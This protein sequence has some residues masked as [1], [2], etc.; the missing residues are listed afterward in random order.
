MYEVKWKDLSPAE[1]TFEPI[2]RHKRFR[3][4][5]IGCVVLCAK[6]EGGGLGG[7]TSTGMY[8]KLQPPGLNSSRQVLSRK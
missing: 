3:L 4:E 5:Q 7:P 1:N 6:R 2:S 8:D